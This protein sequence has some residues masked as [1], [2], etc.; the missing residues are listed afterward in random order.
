MGC[1]AERGHPTHLDSITY[2]PI[3]FSSKMESTNLTC[4]IMRMLFDGGQDVLAGPS[5]GPPS[6]MPPR[7]TVTG[8]QQVQRETQVFTFFF[9]MKTPTIPKGFIFLKLTLSWKDFP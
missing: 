4:T 5:A 3:N 8:Y 2:P 7:S 6:A 9:Q 1:K